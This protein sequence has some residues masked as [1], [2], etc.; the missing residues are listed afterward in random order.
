M[1]N[2]TLLI[3]LSLFIIS[4]GL[5]LKKV[6]I[7]DVGY[8]EV[9]NNTIIKKDL[10]ENENSF[11]DPMTTILLDTFYIKNG[12][13]IHKKVEGD[14]FI[15]DGYSPEESWLY[16]YNL[17]GLLEKEE[18]LGMTWGLTKIYNYDNKNRMIRK[19][20]YHSRTPPKFD[21][22]EVYV[23][24]DSLKIVEIYNPDLNNYPNINKLISNSYLYMNE[25]DM[26][27]I[28]FGELVETK[29]Y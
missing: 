28:Q 9:K 17:D 4:C 3:L 13:L 27:L 6:T 20:S 11:V 18:Y 16:Q 26:D 23:Y 8:F 21:S 14:K 25:I 15:V 10:V 5:K 1:K 7:K 22:M 29:G 24:R 19:D 2:I 12:K